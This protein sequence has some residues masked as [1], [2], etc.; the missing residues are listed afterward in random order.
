MNMLQKEALCMCCNDLTRYKRKSDD[1]S[2]KNDLL[3]RVVS[4]QSIDE[5]QYKV[6]RKKYQNLIYI[7]Q[8]DSTHLHL[9][10]GACDKVNNSEIRLKED[11]LRELLWKVF[12][13]IYKQ[14]D[15]ELY[16]CTLRLLQGDY[17][18]TYVSLERLWYMRKKEVNENE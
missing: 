5:E 13:L 1:V 4:N 16:H 2:R 11:Q 17:P 12:F 6:F 10:C 18:I 14:G 7:L 8:N 15:D 9:M 3:K